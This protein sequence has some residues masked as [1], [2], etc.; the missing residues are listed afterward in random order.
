MI[1]KFKKLFQY[2]KGAIKILFS[3]SPYSHL[4]KMAAAHHV[5]RFLHQYNF[6]I[7]V[8]TNDPAIARPILLTQCY[9]PNVT[10]VLLRH[11][12]P[13]TRF[14]DVGANI[15]YFS[16]LVASHCPKGKI[17]SFEPD[18]EN[19]RL[20]KT[21]IAYNQFEKTITAYPFAVSDSP[22]TLIL[23]D[24]GNKA[25]T[26]AR[27]T[28]KSEKDLAAFI[29]G[30]QPDFREVR[31]ISIDTF[32]SQEHFDLV[33]VDIEGHDLHAF[34]G[35]SKMLE[36]DHPI[37]IAEFAPGNLVNIGQIDPPSFLSFFT[38]L[39]YHL[40]VIDEAGQTIHFDRN[41]NSIMEYQKSSGIHHLDLL[42]NV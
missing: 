19:F 6:S 32:L 24:L 4:K 25:N 3:S 35:M 26:G 18:P 42:M 7:V 36:R 40:H 41:V 17:V 37:I 20:F 5:I 10:R 38:T 11:L 28:G 27:F 14:L 16:L 34:R 29:H 13:D 15:G 31:S 9:E 23:S 8:N 12:R 22:G 39:G 30:P 2:A 33:K 21:S 1:G